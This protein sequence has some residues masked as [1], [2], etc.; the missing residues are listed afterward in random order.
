MVVKFIKIKL[1]D[2]LNIHFKMN[3]HKVRNSAVRGENSIY[4]MNHM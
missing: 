1:P 2:A 3:E 4:E